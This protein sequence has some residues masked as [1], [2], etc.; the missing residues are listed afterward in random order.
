MNDP[1]ASI[2]YS[3][4]FRSSWILA[5]IVERSNNRS[6]F[7]GTTVQSHLISHRYTPRHTHHGYC[8]WVC[9][10]AFFLF[11]F[12]SSHPSLCDPAVGRGCRFDAESIQTIHLPGT[13]TRARPRS[14]VRDIIILLYRHRGP[15]SNVISGR[16]RNA[17]A[18]KGDDV[19]VGIEYYL[20]ERVTGGPKGVENRSRSSET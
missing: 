4:D 18:G 14:R 6:V 3:T 11:L 13:K 20:S 5:R 1:G 16:A 7:S 10:I 17:A 19:T 8:R 2:N 9:N 15:G 12:Q